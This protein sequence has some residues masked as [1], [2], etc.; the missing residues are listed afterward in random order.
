MAAALTGFLL[1]DEHT[2]PLKPPAFP[3]IHAAATLKTAAVWLAIWIVPLLT[4]AAIFG[5]S[6]VIAQIA[7]FFSK[8][9]VVTFGGAYAVLAYM[10]QDV[11]EA[12]RWLAP[13]QM[14]DGLGL[15]E[16]TP[17]PLIL[18]TEFVGFLAAHGHGGGNPWAMGVLG[19]AV[20]L[21]ANFAPCFLW[22]FVGAPFIERLEAEPRLNSALAAVTAAVVGV[23]LNLTV[24][25]ALHTLFGT[26]TVS[27]T[28][29]VRMLIPDAGSVSWPAVLLAA[30]AVV[31]L[32]V[33][34]LG[35]MV[36][37]AICAGLALAW[38]LV[39]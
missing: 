12:Y 14:L 16:T 31:Q 7:L 21:W 11:V 23:I 35:V 17:G 29:S 25:F 9:A 4:L 36:T 37:L 20:A 19:A 27:N 3:R 13:G 34:R 15:A 32:F 18:V 6:H 24:W 39:G 38:H 1:A 8:L 2:L 22:I 26:V 30:L 33:L 10:A 5:S 28:G